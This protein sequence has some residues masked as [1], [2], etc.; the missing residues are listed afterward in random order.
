MLVREPKREPVYSDG[1]TGAHR[2]VGARPVEHGCGLYFGSVDKNPTAYG[3][4]GGFPLLAASPFGGERGSLSQFIRQ[5]QKL[6]GISTEPRKD[7]F[8]Y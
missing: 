1:A 3:R 2:L 8:F 4:Q 5:I 7:L 6:E